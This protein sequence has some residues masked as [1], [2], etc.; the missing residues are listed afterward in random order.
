M[1]PSQQLV[2]QQ[3]ENWIEEVVIGFNLC[4]FASPVFEAK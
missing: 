4:P 2:I 3:T 1:I